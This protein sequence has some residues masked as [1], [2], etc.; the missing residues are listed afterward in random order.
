MLNTAT[1]TTTTTIWHTDMILVVTAL[2]V[3]GSLPDARAAHGL[4]ESLSAYQDVPRPPRRHPLPSHLPRQAGD[5]A[6]NGRPDRFLLSRSHGL[7]TRDA[8]NYAA[9]RVA[10]L[11]IYQ[12]YLRSVGRIKEAEQI[13]ELAEEISLVVG[14]ND[15]SA[16]ALASKVLAFEHEL[17][18]RLPDQQSPLNESPAQPRN[19]D[20]RANGPPRVANAFPR[21]SGPP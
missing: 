1:T 15:E 4:G 12:S 5:G 16:R 7:V 19:R 9:S 14:H 8:G 3:L 2:A 6:N 20:E 13:E 18:S 17:A 11:G 21:T 10:S